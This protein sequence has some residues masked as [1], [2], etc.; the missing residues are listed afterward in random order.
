[1]NC[2]YCM[3]DVHGHAE[4]FAEILKMTRMD[5]K[6]DRL[7]C[8]GDYADWGPEGVAVIRLVMHLSEQGSVIPLIGNHDLMF[9]ECIRDNPGEKPM[10]EREAQRSPDRSWL[11]DNRGLDTWNRYCGLETAERKR[12]E[13]WLDILPYRVDITVQGKRYHL[14]HSFPS[15]I[16]PRKKP[17][18]SQ[19][20]YEAVWEREND[21]LLCTDDISGTVIHGHT[22]N[23]KIRNGHIAVEMHGQEIDIDCGAKILG[24]EDGACLAC[25]RLED[26]KVFYAVMT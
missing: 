13:R 22:I 12:I 2:T 18:F 5:L 3:S 10:T 24:M 7:Y 6:S 15:E 23:E 17:R 20:R 8:L 1:M 25:L 9:L 14:C 19:L 4:A 26:M 16:V 11:I 21:Y